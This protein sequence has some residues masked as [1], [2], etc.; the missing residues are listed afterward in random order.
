MTP[1]RE[2]FGNIPHAAVVLFYC[3]TVL[4]MAVF[5]YGVWRRFRLWRQGLPIDARALVTVNLRQILA[6]LKPGLRRV[7]REGLGQ[8]RVRGRGMAG[9]AHIALFAG[10]MM[11][12]LG[13]T[14]LEIDH[15]AS[16]ISPSL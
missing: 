11:L 4:T 13:T 5:V 16:G 12:F 15:L 8:A 10:F 3:L 14:L 1:T 6:K 2:T 7:L 9:R